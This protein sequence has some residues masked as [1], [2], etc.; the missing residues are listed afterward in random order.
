MTN[1]T[2]PTVSRRVWLSQLLMAMAVTLVFGTTLA[3]NVD[4]KVNTVKTN[5]SIKKRVKA[6]RELCEIGGG[7]L[8]VDKRPGGTTT[9]CNGGDSDGWTCTNAKKS[10][11]C[12]R[13][14]THSPTI[15][16][17]GGG[18]VPPGDNGNEDPSDGGGTDPGGGAHVPPGGGVDP[19]GGG[20]D[21]VLE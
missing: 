5:V 1:A 9:T 15:K 16:A 21:P 18:A 13:T 11:R 8:S 20:S 14:L 17:G 4:A 12:H 3:E 19:T 6:Q 2:A 7:T 10:Y